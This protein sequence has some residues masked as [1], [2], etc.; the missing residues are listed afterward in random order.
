MIRYIFC[1]SLEKIY[2]SKPKKI[3]MPLVFVMLFSDIGQSFH[4]ATKNSD[5][6]KNS[7]QIRINQ[8]NLPYF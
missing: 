7:G 6:N 3:Q 1:E 5:G 2:T 4:P 8:D